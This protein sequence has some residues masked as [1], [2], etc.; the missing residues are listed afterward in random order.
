MPKL[1]K[2]SQFVN[3]A[4]VMTIPLKG[5]L[6]D[7]IIKR[8]EELMEALSDGVKFGVPSDYLGRATTKKDANAAIQ[9]IKEIKHYYDSKAEDVRFYCWSISYQGSWKAT[10]NLKAKIEKDGG[11]G[12]QPNNLNLM[13]VIDYFIKNAEDSDNV[14]EIVISI[15][16]PTIRKSMQVTKPAESQPAVEQPQQQQPTEEQGV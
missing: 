12:K 7:Q 11:F 15:D 10:K 9:R 14:D 16:S 4:E 2:F 8:I 3:E 1:R 6:A 13:K 5:Y